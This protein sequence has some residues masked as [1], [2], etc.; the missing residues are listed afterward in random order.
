MFEIH[1]CKLLQFAIFIFWDFHLYYWPSLYCQMSRDAGRRTSSKSASESQGYQGYRDCLSVSNTGGT[2]RRGAPPSPSSP[3]YPRTE[4]GRPPRPPPPSPR[5]SSLRPRLSARGPPTLVRTLRNTHVLS[6]RRH[7]VNARPAQAQ[8]KD[9]CA[10]DKS[11]FP[12]AP[13]SAVAR[14]MAAGIG[15]GC[16]RRGLE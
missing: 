2:A 12:A 8:A 10:R 15:N 1:K 6:F 5:R 3:G 7:D 16:V 14:K 13:P 4:C 9:A 11:P